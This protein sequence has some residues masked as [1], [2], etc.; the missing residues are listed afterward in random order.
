MGCR[1]PGSK[2]SITRFAGIQGRICRVAWQAR[3][4]EFAYR[5]TSSFPRNRQLGT[6]GIGAGR[7][8]ETAMEPRSPSLREL[9]SDR[10]L[11]I[12]M[13]CKIQGRSRISARG[14]ERLSTP[15]KWMP[16]LVLRLQQIIPMWRYVF[17]LQYGSTAHYQQILPQPFPAQVTRKCSLGRL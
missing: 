12:H 3:P 15:G 4:F 17:G 13:R 5:C 1:G 11:E 2:V 10:G 7:G 14:D 6:V 8:V 9:R 16:Q